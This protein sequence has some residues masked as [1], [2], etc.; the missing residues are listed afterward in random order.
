MTSEDILQE[1]KEAENSKNKTGMAKFGINTE[2]AFG[3]SMPF[4]R[5]LAK[6]I[7]TNHPLA[8]EL[9]NSGYHEPR[10]LAALIADYK[11]IDEQTVDSWVIEFN[12]WDIT[13]Q[14]CMN[15]LRKLPFI[16]KKIDEWRKREE[17]FVKRSAFALIAT[18]SVHDKKR[19]DSDFLNFLTYIEEAADD[20]RNF[21][22]KA[23]NWALRQIGKRN[24][25]LNAESIELCEKLMLTNVKSCKWIAK[26]AYRELTSEK[27]QVRLIEKSRKG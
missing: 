18:I 1:F 4:V 14:Y 24:L 10:I 22:K 3:V 21:V 19:P 23:V 8:L 5:G 9:W 11:Q 12:S 26:D 15:L 7:K 6:E 17:V 16:D 20:D 13:D 25:Y 27:I 2:F